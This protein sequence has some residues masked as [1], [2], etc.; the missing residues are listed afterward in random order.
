MRRR[1]FITFVG[2]ALA[3]PLTAH[4]QQL[5]PRR[6]G[7]MWDSP[8]AF[9]DA[10]LA[11]R[12]ALRELGYVEGQ[13][14]TI[15]YRY[16]EGDPER[17]RAFAEEFVRLE[18]DAI[19]APSSI[20]TAAAKQATSA[21]PIIFMSHADPLGT[22]HVA[23][24]A[25]PSG[26]ATGL[27]LMMTETNVKLLE[28]F[29]EAVPGLSRLAVVYDPSTPS[30]IPGLKALEVAG[31]TLNVKIQPVPVSAANEYEQAFAAM[32][33]E[34][35]EAALFLSTPLY[36]G[37]AKRLA[38]LARA[39]RIASLFGPRHN[40]VSGGLISYSPDRK[41]LW[42]RGAILLDRVLKGANPAEL[43]VEQPTKFELVINLATAKAIGLKI[44][45]AFLLRADEVIE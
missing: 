12:T 35:A 4:A 28:I 25:R 40:V 45:E 30:H 34:R 37:D 13:T 20:Y 17:M 22:G 43:P 5:K 33:R 36:I 26:N 42:R 41:D 27:S 10:M 2:G 15:E 16:A 24:L 6:V 3:W 18:V 9:P 21:I 1:E 14:I 8:T 38:E 19:V 32:V 7:F 31:P 23:T 11:F 39:H 29:K 44:P